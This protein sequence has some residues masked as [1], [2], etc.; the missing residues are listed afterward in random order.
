VWLQ[1]K[2][3][4]GGGQRQEKKPM[5]TKMTETE[6][7]AAKAEAQRKYRANQKKA[8][9]AER[10][11]HIEAELETMDTP[12][13]VEANT[14]PTTPEANGTPAAVASAPRKQWFY[15]LEG[16]GPAGP[17]DSQEAALTDARARMPEHAELL[18]RKKSRF[19]RVG[20]WSNTVTEN[21]AKVK[22][23]AATREGNQGLLAVE[24][25]PAQ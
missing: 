6:R 17:F 11:E 16:Q 18:T 25:T 19:V 9:Q 7:K 12:P 3:K 2:T 23:Y 24:P 4:R 21:G 15:G 14:E 22:F 10:Q 13:A 1:G 20:V 5:K 8:K